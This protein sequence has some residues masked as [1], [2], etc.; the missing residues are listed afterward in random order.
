MPFKSKQQ[1]KWMHANKPTMAKKW[2]AHTPK[3]TKLPMKATVKATSRPLEILGTGETLTILPK[4]IVN[5]DCE[6]CGHTKK[7]PANKLITQPPQQGMTRFSR[8]K[9]LSWLYQYNKD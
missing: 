2:E 8:P 7:L 4:K 5:K 1:R 9:D 6:R 3:N